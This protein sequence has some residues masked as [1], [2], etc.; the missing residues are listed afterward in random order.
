MAKLNKPMYIPSIES[1][2]LYNYMF[3]DKEIDLKFIGM[4]P[5][6]LE[7]NKLIS[8][9]IH[10]TIKKT[11]NK[12]ISCD[13]IN[14][15]FTQKVHSGKEIIKN[16]KKKIEK[17]E[18]EKG[19]YKKKIFDFIKVISEEI[20]DEK[21]S[22]VSQE[23]LRK[24]FYTDGFYYNGAQYVVYKRSSAKS[25]IGQC[26]FIKEK[27]YESMIKW[28]R[29]NIEF[30]NRPREVE[31]DFPSLLAY[32]SL[33]GSSIESTIHINPENILIIE[34]VESIFNKKAHIIRPGASGFLDSHNEMG[35]IRNSLFDGES[36]LDSSYFPDGKAMLL[37]RNHM[38]KSAAFNCNIQQF[39][40]DHCPEDIDYEQWQITSMF[41]NELLYAKDI[42]MITTP[43]SL[44]ALKFSQLLGSELNMWQH[45]KHIVMKDNCIFGVCKS[46]KSSKLGFDSKGNILQQTSYQMLNSLP[47]RKNDIDSFTKL[48]RDFIIRL[49]NDD[50][51]FIQYIKNNANE[52]NSNEMFAELYNINPQIIHTKLFRRFRKDI[53]SSYVA[54]IKKGKIRL[55]GDYCVMLGNGVEYLYHAIGKLDK[56]KPKS[57]SLQ[58][59]EVHTS[60]FEETELIGFRNPHTSP[61][62]VLV[63]KNKNINIINNYFNLSKNIVCVNA[64]EFPLQDILSG[65]DYDSDTVLLIHNDKLLGIAKDIFNKYNVCLN[66]VHS[67]KKQYTV[68]NYDM[69]K[70]DT[71]LSKSQ[72]YIGMTVN[73]GQL[74]MSRYWDL[75]NKGHTETELHELMKKIDVVTILSGMCIDLAKKMFDIDINKEIEHIS[76]TKELKKEKPLFWKH[77]NQNATMQTEVYD[78]PMDYLIK[79]LSGLKYAEQKADI[80]FESFL[81]KHKTRGFNYDQ[82]QK[83]FNYVENMISKIN[84]TYASSLLP[85]EKD[86]RIDDAIKY[87]KFF[88]GKLQVN[89]ETMYSILFKFTSTAIKKNQR[90]K[91]AARL[92]D[93]LFSTHKDVFL[94]SFQ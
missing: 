69:A 72:K 5:S 86:R 8:I 70:I 60:M 45:W 88:I 21:W 3:R 64:I 36:L 59:N 35:S 19:D 32:E 63:V 9:G 27:F 14:V 12:L 7:L 6:S 23:H 38:F 74:C 17:L 10:T 1:C 50:I 41:H 4:I 16:C 66:Q 18:N 46:E 80:S 2:D 81:I 51:F 67:S 44:K 39:F 43:S 90:E 48:E 78:C 33:V 47:L 54:H 55:H 49:K 15:K 42:L 58:N 68:S 13:I 30:R 94:R 79:E 91:I 37:L 77:I 92:L 76:K 93:I 83:I 75:F 52:I 11:S 82:E 29:M 56:N 62:N 20:N 28:S 24:K 26:L 87:C 71:E 85:E 84:N 25:R 89:K 22:A 65:S 34:D 53:V 61:K 57:F 73:I 40:K 31:I